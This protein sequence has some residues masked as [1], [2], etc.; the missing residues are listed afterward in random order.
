MGLRVR[1]VDTANRPQL[2]R[3]GSSPVCK[4]V[5]VCNGRRIATAWA[6]LF[7]DEVVD[8][9]GVRTPRKQAAVSERLVFAVEQLD[10]EHD[11]ALLDGVLDLTRMSRDQ[12]V[13]EGGLKRRGLGTQPRREAIG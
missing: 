3:P 6:A 10:P 4:S 5:T 8:A 11:P 9:N 13:A 1:S 2:C 7:G 12:P